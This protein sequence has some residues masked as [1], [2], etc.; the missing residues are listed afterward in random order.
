MYNLLVSA[1]IESWRGGPFTFERERF[2]E[3]TD[4]DIQIK[5]REITDSKINE[6]IQFPCV[7]AYESYCELDPLFGFIKEVQIRSKKIKVYYEVIDLDAFLTWKQI[8]EIRFELDI[9]RLELSRTHWALKKVDLI[10]E[11]NRKN[12]IIPELASGERNAIDITKHQFDVA[13]SFPGEVRNFI[14]P[15]AAELERVIGPNSCFYDNNYKA[16]LA[17]PSLDLLLQSIYKKRAKLIVVFVC[18]KYQEKEWCGL[19]FTAIR[20]IILEKQLGKIM[21]IKMDDGKVEG[22]FKNDGYI[23]GRTHSP[24]EVALLIKKRIDVLKLE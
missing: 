18:S 22:V 20:E 9:N 19:E 3:H 17:R 6:I 21:Y 4:E 12:L 5:Y 24:K 8:K 14:E 16:Q 15:I 1:D 2:L 13:F 11:L 7:F 10:K 23:D